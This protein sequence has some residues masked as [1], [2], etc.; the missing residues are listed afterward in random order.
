M[1]HISSPEYGIQV[2]LVSKC[3]ESKKGRRLKLKVN[4]LH[5]ILTSKNEVK[6]QKLSFY[7]IK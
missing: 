4:S 2:K 5:Q 6:G 3:A 1:N 7:H